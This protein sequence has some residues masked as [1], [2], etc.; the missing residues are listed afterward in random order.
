VNTIA[1]ALIVRSNPPF[2]AT[3]WVYFLVLI[4]LM[5]VYFIRLYRIKKKEKKK[6]ERKI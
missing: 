1:R 4:S 2:L 3:W 5:C 6:E